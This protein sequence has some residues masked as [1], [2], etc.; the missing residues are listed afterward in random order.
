MRAW[1]CVE[2]SS[3]AFCE[4]PLL[5]QS[6]PTTGIA[7]GKMRKPIDRIE[8]YLSPRILNLAFRGLTRWH[9]AAS[10]GI[11]LST[12]RKNR[13]LRVPATNRKSLVET[14]PVSGEPTPAKPRL[15]RDRSGLFECE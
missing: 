4:R 5:A 8:E 14:N 13:V 2:G 1:G 10:F 3:N 6:G 11:H 15:R 9:Y 12:N 7:V